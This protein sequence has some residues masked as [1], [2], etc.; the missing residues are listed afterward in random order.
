MNAMGLFK[1]VNALIL[2]LVILLAAACTG[3]TARQEQGAFLQATEAP[4]LEQLTAATASSF[5]AKSYFYDTAG[6]LAEI[7]IKNYEIR[8]NKVSADTIL[9]GTDAEK[10]VYNAAGQL[11]SRILIISEQHPDSVFERRDFEYNAHKQVSKIIYTT[12]RYAPASFYTMTCNYDERQKLSKQSLLNQSGQ[13]MAYNILS[14]PTA[15]TIKGESYS[16]VQGPPV[17]VSTQLATFDDRKCPNPYDRAPH[18]FMVNL[19]DIRL[20]DNN[21]V[22]VS[23][24]D[25]YRK[26]EIRYSYKYNKSGFPMECAEEPN[27]IQYTYTYK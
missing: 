16:A 6:R 7:Q 15:N 11:A 1:K 26:Q 23:I 27:P 3:N 17:L 4:F 14:Y 21:L 18:H 19:S 13:V 24:Q 9:L 12:K 8:H 2:G 10:F 22:S 25:E 5:I 20:S